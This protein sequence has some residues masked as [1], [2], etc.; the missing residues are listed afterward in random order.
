MPDTYIHPSKQ[1]ELARRMA[2]LGLREADLVEKFILG[3][4]RGGQKINKTSSCVY[5]KHT[6]SGEEVKC[7]GSRSREL[8]RLLARRE[9]CDRIE[10]AALGA[11]SRRHQEA[12]RIRRQ[13]RRRSRRQKERMLRD[14]HL[15]SEKKSMRTAVSIGAAILLCLVSSG[16]CAEEGPLPPARMSFIQAIVLGVTEG[17][18]EYLPV[19]STGHLLLVQRCMGLGQEGADKVA[20]DAYAICIQAGAILAVLGLYFRRI[21]RIVVGMFGRDADGLR[22]GVNLVVAFMPAALIGVAL[23]K[24]IKRYLFGDGHW[25]LW[26]IVAAWVVGG[27]VILL[28]DRWMGAA[29]AA[30]S[31]ARLPLERLTWQMAVCIGLAQCL[32]MWPG[33]SRSLATILGGLAV[34]LGLGAAVE[35]SFLLGLIT[36][37]A[38]TCLDA[39]Q[40]G[41]TIISVYGIL[42]PIAGLLVAMVSAALAVKWMVA[43]LQRHSMAIF[44]YYRIALALLTA[45]VLLVLAR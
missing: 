3:S 32:A 26:P 45:G 31:R 19:S 2:A 20:A 29:R 5:L 15:H 39:L 6:P 11:A 21:Q 14:K 8:N 33:V 7:Q 24:V 41:N 12:E 23:E 38:S 34:G 40:H 25:G 30:S 1:Q 18:T 4:G 36:L 37:T 13:K 43:Y 22:L 44:A 28:V 17:V 16:A 9:L 27:V 10:S 35:F 42:R